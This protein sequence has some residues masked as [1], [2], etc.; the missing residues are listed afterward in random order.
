MFQLFYAIRYRE[1][2][3]LNFGL[4]KSGFAGQ[5]PFFRL[6]P[7][8][9]FRIFSYISCKNLNAGI[10]YKK[11]WLFGNSREIDLHDKSSK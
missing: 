5:Y 4:N 9:L 3:S 1:L 6:F 2:Y 8:E 11:R 10:Q 7:K